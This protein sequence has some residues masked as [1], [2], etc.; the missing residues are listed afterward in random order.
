M[1]LINFISQ[2]FELAQTDVGKN[3]TS[4]AVKTVTN[5]AKNKNVQIAVGSI[6]AAGVAGVVGNSL[7]RD[8]GTKEGRKAGF[9]E[10]FTAGGIATKQ[11]FEHVLSMVRSRDEF[12][13]LAIKIAVHIARCDDD[14]SPEEDK[15][16]DRYIGQL[17]ASP[18]VPEVIKNRIFEIK[19][20]NLSFDELVTETHSFLNKYCNEEDK[21]EVI[22]YIYNLITDIIAADGI[23]HPAEEAFLDKWEKEFSI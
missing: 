7:G 8:K 12:I 17:N 23:V 11:K 2:L 1:N 9:E 6:A 15:E 22:S 19:N 13:L 18:V 3:F 16:I 14:F 4:N 10:G 5:I 20:T 21:R